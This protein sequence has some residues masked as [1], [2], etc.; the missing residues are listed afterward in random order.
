MITSAPKLSK[1]FSGQVVDWY[2]NAE[3]NV[4]LEQSADGWY[5]ELPLYS[6]KRITTTATTVGTS[7]INFSLPLIRY[8]RRR[9]DSFG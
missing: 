2:G 8:P 5:N 4:A 9:C 7:L 3:R 1:T 6:I